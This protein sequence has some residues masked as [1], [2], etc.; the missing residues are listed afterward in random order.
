MHTFLKEDITSVSSPAVVTSVQLPAVQS[1][2]KHC[3]PFPI[4]PGLN[5]KWIKYMYFLSRAR[6]YHSHPLH[7]HIFLSSDD[8][9]LP[10]RT[11]FL[12]DNQIC[13]R[14]TSCFDLGQ[15]KYLHLFGK[16]K[17]FILNSSRHTSRWMLMESTACG[18]SWRTKRSPWNNKIECWEVS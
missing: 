4:R 17:T 8:T 13:C 5:R 14:H 2:A 7:K 6:K 3:W 18:P 10:F 9:W 15:T 12:L 11:L 1:P 16:D